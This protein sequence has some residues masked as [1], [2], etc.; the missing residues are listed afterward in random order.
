MAGT[1]PKPRK[2]ARFRA[3]AS[4]PDGVIVY[5]ADEADELAGVERRHTAAGSPLAVAEWDENAG[6]YVRQGAAA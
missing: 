1:G 2:S 4:T 6:A 3:A 5:S